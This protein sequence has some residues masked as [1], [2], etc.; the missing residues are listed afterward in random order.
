MGESKKRFT[1]WI[2]KYA[3]TQGI[4]KAEVEDCFDTAPD[5]V[6]HVGTPMTYYYGNNWHRT[7]E[8]AVERVRVMIKSAR[9]ALDKKR[10]KLDALEKTIGARR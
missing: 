9:E 6:H 7:R 1:V 10:A 8:D 2:T 4:F 3:L 5:M